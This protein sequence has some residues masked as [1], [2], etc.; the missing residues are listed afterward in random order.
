MIDAVLGR[1]GHASA[2]FTSPHLV[3][4]SERF[5][6]RGTP[7]A[8]DEMRRS[9]GE[10]QQAI[11]ALLSDGTFSARPTFFEATTAMAFELFRRARVDFAVIEVGLGGRLDSTNVIDPIVTAITSIDFDH[12]QYLGE[13]LPEIAGEK[14]GIIKPG[15]PIVVGEMVPDA[16]AVIERIARERGAQLIRSDEAARDYGTITLG[17]RGAHQA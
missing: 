11:E 8:A 1:A 12:Q 7:V 16:F 6:I 17:L 4:L 10:V 13:S 2:R 9:A 5:V 15:V 14:A 3:D